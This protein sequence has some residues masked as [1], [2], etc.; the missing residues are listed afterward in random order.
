MVDLTDLLQGHQAAV[1]PITGLTCLREDP[2]GGVA[3]ALDLE[4]LAERLGPYRSALVEQCFDLA[5]DEGVS[6]EGRRV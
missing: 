5:Q 6:L 1:G 2:T 3:V 4:V